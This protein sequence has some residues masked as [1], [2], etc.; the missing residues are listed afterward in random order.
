M[1]NVLIALTVC[2]LAACAMPQPQKQMK[3]QHDSGAGQA[4][5]NRDQGQCEGQAYS[6]TGR[7]AS[8]CVGECAERGLRIYLACMQSN[9]WR[10]VEQ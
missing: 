2:F 9:G 5:Y 6:V 1:K 7:S 3:W 10:L 8:R 4:Q